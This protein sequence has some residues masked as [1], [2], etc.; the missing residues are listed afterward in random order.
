MWQFSN[1]DLNCK[2][3]A[4][5]GCGI[6]LQTGKFAFVANSRAR[7]VDDTEGMVKFIADASTDKIL[8]AHI[9]GPNAGELIHECAQLSLNPINS[10]GL[11]DKKGPSLR[12]K[13]FKV[14]GRAK[15]L[16]AHVMGPNVG[17]ASRSMPCRQ[18]LDC[19]V[20]LRHI[21]WLSPCCP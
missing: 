8:G 6:V 15:A 9:M 18:T 10:C 17:V 16:G 14:A 19:Y 2:T 7:S 4:N 21:Y 20:P 12:K 13:R 3:V 1:G 11:M 5:Q